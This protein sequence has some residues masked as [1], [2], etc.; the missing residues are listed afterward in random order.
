L[1]MGWESIL[2]NSG[3][4]QIFC[5]EKDMRKRALSIICLL[6]GVSASFAMGQGFTFDYMAEAHA[7][8]SY[9]EFYGA[10]SAETYRVYDDAGPSP[11]PVSASASPRAGGE[12]SAEEASG[13]SETG[14]SVVA[15]GLEMYARGGIEGIWSPASA[16][17]SLVGTFS[18][19]GDGDTPFAAVAT[20]PSSYQSPD[21]AWSVEV[22]EASDPGTILFRLDEANLSE[23][24]TL[25]AGTVYEVELD[26]E[27]EGLWP[28]GRVDVQFTTPT[29]DGGRDGDFPDDLGGAPDGFVDAFDIDALADAILNGGSVATFDLNGDLVL[30]SLDMD[31]LIAS[32]VDTSTMG[33]A[34]GTFFGDFNLDGTVDL[35]DLNKLTAN[36]NGLGGWA[37][38]DS[39]GDGSIQLLDLNKLTA[40]YN[41]TVVVPEPATMSL[42]AMGAIA[43]LRR[44]K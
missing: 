13:F 20:I 42:L 25:Q 37:D 7:M 27:L 31:M 14:G 24:L 11:F 12:Y 16:S 34:S 29:P 36:Y 30:D 9:T 35:L 23:E 18:I 43:M 44:R 19:V 41:S 33:E 28:D 17:T 2:T 38:G 40:N 1:L 8:G 39:N 10:G 3:R 5:K 4:D 26:L 22:W 6:V 32:L 15:G 21:F